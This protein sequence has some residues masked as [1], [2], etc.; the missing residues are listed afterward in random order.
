MKSRRW[1]N[2]LIEG[3]IAA[4]ALITALPVVLIFITALKPEA[5]IIRFDGV[6]PQDPTLANFR[7][8]LEY[9]EEAPILR[10][11]FNSVLVASGT[12]FLVLLVSSLAAFVLSRLRPVGGRWV[13]LG[14]IATLMVPGQVVFVPLYLLLSNLG[15]LDTYWALIL[16]PAASPFG[17]FLIY[18]FMKQ[19]PLEVEEAAR[20][21]GCSDLQLYR[22]VMLPLCRPVLATL[23]IFVFVGSWNDFL[24]PLIFLDS[25]DRYTL[26]V[27]VAIFQSSY[28]T[29]Y[30]LT[31]AASVVCTLPVVVAFLLFSKHIVRGISSGAVKG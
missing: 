10:W 4:A 21:D 24:G 29:D 27:G 1:S 17:V 2:G 30:G 18:Q 9:P 25:I 8:F 3:F 12:T 28:A 13:L 6:L 14:I 19:V 22:H 15:L 26:P 23:G 31:L 5:E 7:H 16:P 11:L 20:L